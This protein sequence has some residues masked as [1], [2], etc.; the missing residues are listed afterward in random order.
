MLEGSVRRTGQQVRI[1]AQLIEAETG[2]HVWADRFDGDRENL[3]EMQNDV[4][5]SA[6]RALSPEIVQ[7][8][9][10]RV[11]RQKTLSL[12]TLDHITLGWALARRASTGERLEDAKQHFE[13]ALEQ[14]H[15]AID[16]LTGL[17]YALGRSVSEG[18]VQDRA[19]RLARA[20]LLLLRALALD[21][22]NADG[23][24]ARRMSA[25]WKLCRGPCRRWGGIEPIDWS[26]VDTHGLRTD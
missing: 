4:T 26:V 24:A 21:P 6:A 23:R 15:Q 22:G 25:I 12:N 7:A 2:A 1:N 3:L 11:Q 18:C 14:E 16:A 13:A 20:E 17:G 5:A 8:D 10:R 19:E 9:A